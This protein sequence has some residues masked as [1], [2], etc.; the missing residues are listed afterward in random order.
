MADL[1]V[2]FQQTRVGDALIHT[3]QGFSPVRAGKP[4]GVEGA[5]SLI[6][7]RRGSA[8]LEAPRDTHAIGAGSFLIRRLDRPVA[9]TNGPGTAGMSLTLPG[10]ALGSLLGDR[11]VRGES[12]SAEMRLLIAYADLLRRTGPE[13]AA[14]MRS[15]RDALVELTVGVLRSAAGSE[16]TLTAPA[17]AD[18]ARRLADDRLA[19]R[20]LGPATLA[21][22]LHV[23]TRTLHRAFAAE[24]EPVMAYIRRQRLVRAGQDLADPDGR[25]TVAEIAARWQFSDSGHLSRAFKQRY[26][27]T[28][29]DYARRGPTGRP[30]P[31][32]SPMS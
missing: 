26:G 21:A 4:A 22:D 13:L 30:A 10:A 20:D 3:H 16:N 14:G 8:T 17:L 29:T 31:G 6:L 32:L 23:S 5:V 15:A 28:P 12:G 7:V 27:C 9:F 11:I 24:G 19:D 1:R 18:A 25:L 2:R